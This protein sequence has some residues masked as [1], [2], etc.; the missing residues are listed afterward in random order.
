MTFLAVSMV[1]T[2][3]AVSCALLFEAVV[4]RPV[5][6]V[7]QVFAPMSYRYALVL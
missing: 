2:L 3:P 4:G 5:A 1:Y 6:T 7:V